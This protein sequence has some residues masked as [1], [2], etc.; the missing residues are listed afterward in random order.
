MNRIKLSIAF[1]ALLLTACSS[2]QET[3]LSQQ[4][5]LVEIKLSSGLDVMTRAYTPTQA[6][7]IADNEIVYAWVDNADNTQ[8]YPAW[9]LKASSQNLDSNVATEPIKY[10]PTTSTGEVNVYALHGNFAAG[11][12]TNG[13][14]AYPTAAFTHSVLSNQQTAGNYEKSDLLYAKNNFTRSTTR[15]TMEFKHMLSKIEVGLKAGAGAPV[16]TGATVEIMNTK[17]DAA[18]T[19]TKA[20]ASTGYTATEIVAGGTVANITMK[21][22]AKDGTNG[23]V[24]TTGATTSESDVEVFG[25]AIIVPQTITASSTAKV[26]F[27]KV[28]LAS[29]GVLYAKLSANTTFAPYKKYIYIVTVELTGLTLSS[30]IADWSTDGVINASA[31]MD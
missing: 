25:E 18:V 1:A 23:G 28:T 30:T 27:I 21:T 13:T 5:N 11:T 4:E 2:D 14:T 15:Q 3:E 16:L 26:N 20:T 9:E 7:A 31:G 29:G 12:F 24:V 19:L 8:K 6:T 17:P 22:T 10:Y